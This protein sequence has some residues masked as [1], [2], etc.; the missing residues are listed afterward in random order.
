MDNQGELNHMSL[1]KQKRRAE[2]KERIK[3]QAEPGL[4]A[5][6]GKKEKKLNSANNKQA[7]KRTLSPG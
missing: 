1:E 5:R 2:E 3:V 6:L 7:G 4:S